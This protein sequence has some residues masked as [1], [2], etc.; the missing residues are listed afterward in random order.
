MSQENPLKSPETVPLTTEE[1]VR[2]TWLKDE[3][4]NIN[5]CSPEEETEQELE[6]SHE[7]NKIENI[8]QPEENQSDG[9]D[10]MALLSRQLSDY[11]DKAEDGYQNVQEPDD[12]LSDEELIKRTEQ[13]KC[14]SHTPTPP[15]SNNSSN[16]SLHKQS[17]KVLQELLVFSENPVAINNVDRITVIRYFGAGKSGIL[18]SKYRLKRRQT[19][20]YLVAFDFSDESDN[21]L[22]WAM[23]SILRD[24][25]EIHV[26]TVSNRE[27][28]PDVVKASGL[29]KGS[30]LERISKMLADRARRTMDQMLL[31]S[32]KVVTHAIV[33]RVKE[34]LKGLIE[35][36]KYDMVIC[37]SR[38]RSSVK[39]LLMGSVSTYLVHATPVP[40]VVVRKKQ[41]KPK[42]IRRPSGSHSLSESMRIGTLKV[43]ELS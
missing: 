23:G 4:E 18:P 21:A 42:L 22:N 2:R 11:E 1:P 9:V 43:D 29:D 24:G 17:E 33:G 37:G 34:K 40:V 39:R 25:D 38:G 15:L 19:K 30:E 5:R 31:F 7:Q 13:N 16:A 35:E 32:I 20:C 10:M 41:E 14:I 36:N 27:D 8:I 3:L 6:L 26:A 12:K 28:N